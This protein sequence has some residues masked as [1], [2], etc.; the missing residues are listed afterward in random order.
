MLKNR[1]VRS[2]VMLFAVGAVACLLSQDAQAQNCYRG[3]RGGGFRISI[4]YG[5]YGGYGSSISYYAPRYRRGPAWS[6]HYGYH[7]GVYGRRGY[8]YRSPHFHVHR[9][10]HYPY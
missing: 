6:P 9:M 8:G 1:F 5:G 10:G 7:P 2:A 4:G 3:S